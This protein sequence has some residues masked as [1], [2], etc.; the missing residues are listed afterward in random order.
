MTY[1]KKQQKNRRKKLFWIIGG[2]I[3]ILAILFLIQRND[4][5]DSTISIS[6]LDDTA[7]VYIDR[8]SVSPIT[9][10]S[11]PTTY[12]VSAG[13]R[14][15]LIAREG[16]WPWSQQVDVA[17]G[18]TVEIEP[19]LIEEN[20]RRVLQTT[21][22]I[23]S[24]LAEAQSAPVPSSESPVLS[25]NEDIRVYVDNET[26]IIAQWTGST[27]TAPT[28]FDCYEG[29]CGVSVINQ[30]P[31]RQIEFYPGRD[32]VIFFATNTGVYAI[33]IDPRGETQNFQPVVESVQNPIFTISDGNIFVLSGSRIT[34]SDI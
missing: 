26:N 30:A 32:D 18:E 6:P 4:A 21:E 14:Q 33:E 1:I 5:A 29:T 25:D 13:S 8:S 11:S 24:S 22:E 28:F 27:S 17:D 20:G 16:Y 34:V 2:I 9:S 3:I 7:S 15:I 19:F 12:D 31:I 23:T 10:T